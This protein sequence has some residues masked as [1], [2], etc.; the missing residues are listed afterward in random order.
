[1]KF[2]CLGYYDEKAFEA[3]SESEQHALIDT[4]LAYDEELKKNGHFAGGEA[5]QHSSR[6]VTLR[7]SKGKVYATDGPFTETK[8]MLGSLLV[9]EARDIAHAIELMSRHPGVKVG[10]FEIEAPAPAVRFRPGH[11]SPQSLA[12]WSTG[13]RPNSLP[14]LPDRIFPFSS[15]VRSKRSSASTA[16]ASSICG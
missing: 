2:I 3:L 4:C 14:A 15:S 11:D 12:G 5:L 6:A 10:P 1:M 16:L 13:R 9:L 7:Y 8:E